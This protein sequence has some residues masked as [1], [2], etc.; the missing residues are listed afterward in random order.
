MVA[1]FFD[2]LWLVMGDV[3]FHKESSGDT[4]HSEEHGRA[5]N[6]DGKLTPRRSRP[7]RGSGTVE[8]DSVGTVLRPDYSSTIRHLATEP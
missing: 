2:F 1:G 6:S 3:D 7:D 4:R 8:R 5:I